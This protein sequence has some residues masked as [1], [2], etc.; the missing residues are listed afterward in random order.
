MTRTDT[1]P[2]GLTLAAYQHLALATAEPRAFHLDYLIPGIVGEVGEL[3]GQRA[4]AYWHGWPME[5][6]QT[7]LVSEYGDIAWMTALLLHSRGV[8]SLQPVVNI[9]PSLNLGI[10]NPHQ[11]LLS[12]ASSLHTQWLLEEQGISETDEWLDMAAERLWRVLRDNCEAITGRDFQYV[13]DANLVKL[14]D[15]AA[16]GVLRGSGDH[17]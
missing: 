11:S 5:K 13:L 15:R 8:A 10:L 9:P 3:F 17:R 14:A 2:S 16:R 1:H 7:E 4:K 6:L 12:A